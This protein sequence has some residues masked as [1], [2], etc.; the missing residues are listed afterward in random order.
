MVAMS[1]NG[2]QRGIHNYWHRPG[3]AKSVLLLACCL[4]GAAVEGLVLE[5]YLRRSGAAE[6]GLAD[7]AG[8]LETRGAG[9]NLVLL[10]CA[11]R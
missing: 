10:C 2:R 9:M 3:G 5:A 11:K 1:D 8:L 6:A 4:L 7:G